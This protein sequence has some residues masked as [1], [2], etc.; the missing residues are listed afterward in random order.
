MITLLISISLF[1]P[2]FQNKTKQ[3]T[4]HPLALNNSKRQQCL[5]LN[6]I[7][8]RA[9]DYQYISGIMVH[10]DTLCEFPIKCCALDIE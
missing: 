1:S 7:K 6:E 8:Y 2:A 5:G 4:N 3:R 9:V 10:F